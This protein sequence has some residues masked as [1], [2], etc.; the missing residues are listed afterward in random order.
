LNFF[1]L[2]RFV[3]K[4]ATTDASIGFHLQQMRLA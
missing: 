1:P 3:V 2:A 4:A